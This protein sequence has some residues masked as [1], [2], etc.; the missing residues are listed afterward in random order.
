MDKPSGYAKPPRE[1]NHIK[2]QED[3]GHTQPTTNTNINQTNSPQKE[4]LEKLHRG[5]IH[6]I[7]TQKHY[8]SRENIV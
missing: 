4:K 1:A 3:L 8:S 5:D 6:K 2:S 7:T